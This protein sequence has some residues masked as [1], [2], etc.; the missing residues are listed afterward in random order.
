M[1]VRIPVDALVTLAKL[2]YGSSQPLEYHVVIVSRKVHTRL[3]SLYGSSG[4]SQPRGLG[5]RHRPV[6][7]PELRSGGTS[8]TN[9]AAVLVSTCT[10]ILL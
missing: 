1:W 7:K 3:Q 4:T 2:F 5:C 6:T 8:T 9:F 10:I